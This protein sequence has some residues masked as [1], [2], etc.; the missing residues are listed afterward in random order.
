VGDD[1]R[2]TEQRWTVPALPLATGLRR[3]DPFSGELFPLAYA[4]DGAPG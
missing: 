3:G 4:A 2:Y 1:A